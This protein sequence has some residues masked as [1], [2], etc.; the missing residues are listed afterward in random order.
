[1]FSAYSSSFILSSIRS[2]CVNTLTVFVLFI[3]CVTIIIRYSFP[4]Y[5]S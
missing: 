1:M 4:C 2:V 3:L 5:F